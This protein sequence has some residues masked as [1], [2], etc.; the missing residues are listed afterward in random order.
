MKR[1][2]PNLP[3]DAAQANLDQAVRRAMDLDEDV[4]RLL[5]QDDALEGI[6]GVSLSFSGCIFRRVRFGENDIEHMSF[7]DCLL[8]HCDF[9]GFRLAEGSMHRVE[10]VSCRGIGAQFDRSVLRDA[11]FQDCCIG[12]MTLSECKLTAIE[13][14]SSELQ[15]LL[16]YDCALKEV[17]FE[18]CRMPGSE[19]SGTSLKDVDLSSDDISGL[20]AQLSCLQGAVISAVQ[21]PELCALLGMKVK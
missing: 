4:E 18:G 10:V 6:E 5:F 11:L 21:A 9:S 20:K 8:D 14:V 3:A 16:L 13:F 15:N 17:R 12:Y 19:V 7:T 1:K 2:R